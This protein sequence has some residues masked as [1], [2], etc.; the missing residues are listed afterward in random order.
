M[1]HDYKPTMPEITSLCL[2]EHSHAHNHDQSNHTHNHELGHSHGH[3]SSKR[4]KRYRP[5]DFDMD[6]LRST[7]KQ[8][9]RDWSEEVP[10]LYCQSYSMDDSQTYRA[11][12]SEKAAT[13]L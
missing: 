3:S 4:Q 6:K 8:F 5:T 2:A 11:K 13:S 9:V 12:R 1:L 10:H 7:I